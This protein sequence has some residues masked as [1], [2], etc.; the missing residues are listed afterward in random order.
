MQ[1]ENK[2][3]RHVQQSSEGGRNLKQRSNGMARR[4]F[5]LTCHLWFIL[6]FTTLALP[7][8]GTINTVVGTGVVGFSGDG[9]PAT[10]ARL[11]F[12]AE[13]EVDAAGNLY[14]ADQLND[15]VRKVN[16]SGII[17]TVAGTGVAGFSGD[18]G[19]A[20]AARL[21]EPIDLLFDGSG[22]LYIADHD[23]NRIRKVDTGGIITTVAGTGVAGFSGDGGAAHRR[24]FEWTHRSGIGWGWQSLYCRYWQQP[25]SQGEYRRHHC[26]GRGN[27]RCRFFWRW[28]AAA[29]TAQL[30]SHNGAAVD[31]S[32]DLYIADRDNHRI[33]KVFAAPPIAAA[34][35][36]Q[37]ICTG[38]EVTLGATPAATGG[39]PPYSFNWTAS[40]SDPSLTSPRMR[41]PRFRQRSLSPTR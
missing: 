7:Q 2:S 29:T 21:H 37:V 18:G 20:T 24:K 27:G 26:D 30:D 10:A 1:L 38:T 13:T 31:G 25:C 19:P 14:I 22:N 5:V 39:T 33:R 8:P 23:N 35:A 40:P 12:P 11:N 9:G 3:I 17:T 41:T 34:G 15:R 32:G 16:T 4:F 36:D 28:R 6:G